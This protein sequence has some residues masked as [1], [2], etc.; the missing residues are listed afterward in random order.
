MPQDDRRPP[1]ERVLGIPDGQGGG[2]A[3]PFLAMAEVGDLAL[4]EFEYEGEPAIVLWDA[5]RESAMAFHATVQGQT[6][7]F[8]VT[9]DGVMD[10]ATE[11]IW[12]VDGSPVGGTLE[13]TGVNLR[14]VSQAYVAFWRAWAAFHPETEL[15]LGGE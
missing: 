6:T 14:P 7:T 12:A 3:F 4:F 5:W 9:D 11:T 1:K 10:E 13:G 8:R 15:A 2:L